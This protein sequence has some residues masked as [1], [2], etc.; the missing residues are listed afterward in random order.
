[1][2]HLASG[3]WEVSCLWFWKG[4][5]MFMS[6]KSFSQT[7]FQPHCLLLCKNSRA[8]NR[9]PTLLFSKEIKNRLVSSFVSEAGCCQENEALGQSVTPEAGLRCPGGGCRTAPLPPAGAAEPAALG[10][11]D[12]VLPAERCR[13]PRVPFASAILWLSRQGWSSSAL[14]P[15]VP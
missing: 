3:G 6:S 11:R 13:Q 8:A 2:S 4:G 5:R 15:A 14:F 7:L 10:A 9:E 1:M 12:G